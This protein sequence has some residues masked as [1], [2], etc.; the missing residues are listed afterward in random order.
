MS[1][2]YLQPDEYADF[3]VDKATVT[4]VR[5]ASQLIDGYLGRVEGLI[6]VPDARGNPCYMKGPNPKLTIQGTATIPPGPTIQVPYTGA[7]LDNNFI[8]EVV[9]LDREDD[10]LVEACVIQAVAPGLVTLQSVSVSHNVGCKMDFGLTIMEEFELP[11]DRS[12]ARLSKSP[13]I[14]LL[15]GAGRYGYG[16]RS[17]QITG[18]FQEFNLLAAVSSFGG[19][20]LWIP[21]DPV[22][23]SVNFR[24]GEVWVPAGILLAYFTDVRTWYIA[25]FQQ[26]GL[27]DAVK[28]A[29]A[30]II[31]LGKD[32]GLGANV[33]GR[34]VNQSMSVTKWENNMID[35]NTRQILSPYKSRRFV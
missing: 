28:Q 12:I 17:D 8:G 16:R 1:S 18:D 35:A 14:K 26:S 3:G 5:A 11:S 24:T 13:A 29:C 27:D 32:S 10:S 20:P 21:W 7:T 9:I 30:N 6:W 2:I 33:R 22:N 34:T 23:A 15:S 4:Q 31:M 19:P 25:G